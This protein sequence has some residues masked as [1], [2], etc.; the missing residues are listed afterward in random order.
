MGN[1]MQKSQNSY[2]LFVPT[3]DTA[4]INMLEV[5]RVLKGHSGVVFIAGLREVGSKYHKILSECNYVVETVEYSGRRTRNEQFSTKNQFDQE[6]PSWVSDLVRWL[7]N[8]LMHVV[9]DF[10]MR[11]KRANSILR[12]I[13]RI[14]GRTEEIVDKYNFTAAVFYDDRS[15]LGSLAMI[16]VCNE[17]GIRTVV[18]TFCDTATVESLILNIKDNPRYIVSRLMRDTSLFSGT[19]LAN[20]SGKLYSYYGYISQDAYKRAGIQSFNP[21]VM[22][23]GRIATVLADGE[24]KRQRLIDHGCSADKIVITGIPQHDRLFSAAQNKV[25]LISVLR[26]KYDIGEVLVIIS[27]PQLAEHGILSW[28]RHWEEIEYLVRALEKNSIMALISLH[29]KMSRENYIFVEKYGHRII[30]ESLADILPAADFFIATFS[31]TVQWSVMLKIPTVVVDFYDLNYS[32]WDNVAGVQVV[33][34]K[35]EF[36]NQLDFLMGDEQYRLGLS[37]S[38]KEFSIGMSPFD[39]KC[40]ERLVS[41]LI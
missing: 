28:Q 26:N 25:E 30:D 22:G 31:S 27:L 11:R 12:I 2:V 33:S 32:D 10:I 38:L 40:T 9:V 4:W 1:I 29:P 19:K 7:H 23:G 17:K 39:G 3:N 13:S 20:I 21:W 15:N 8:M 16:Q 24:S 34:E 14:R 6:V 18:P 35:S 36:E 37:N 41:Y 5:A